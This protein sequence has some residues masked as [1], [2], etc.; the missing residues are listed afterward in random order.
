MGRVIERVTGVSYERY[1]QRE[2]LAPLGVRRMRPGKT[3]PSQRATT[4]VV[5]YDDKNPTASA[6][7]GSIGEHVPLPYGAWSLDAMDANGGCVASAMEL[8]AF[9]SAFV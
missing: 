1:I 8:V 4:E 3:P 9:A 2:V 7:V 6:V 5:Y